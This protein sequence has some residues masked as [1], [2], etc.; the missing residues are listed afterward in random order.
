MTVAV[1]AATSSVPPEEVR[2]AA[3]L[4]LST[5]KS[6]PGANPLSD[7]LVSLQT[8]ILMTIA[9]E[10]SGPSSSK[11]GT[12]LGSSVALANSLHLQTSRYSDS[13]NDSDLRRSLRRAWLSLV[14][15][16][17]WHA[18]AICTATLI[19]DE[20]V[21]LEPEDHVVLGSNSYH[22]LREFLTHSY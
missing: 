22:L 11:A 5:H 9:D 18:A 20:D 16:D 14:I 2:A 13:S 17:R 7:G 15:L 10:L 4:C 6:S 19:H 12:W 1:K 3:H 21:D 8:Y